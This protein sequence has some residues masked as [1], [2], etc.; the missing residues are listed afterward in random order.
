[1]R[2][3][4]LLARVDDAF[5]VRCCVDVVRFFELVRWSELFR[6]FEPERPDVRAL[7]LRTACSV[8]RRLRVSLSSRLRVLLLRAGEAFFDDD[9]D[10]GRDGESG[11]LDAPRLELCSV[12]LE[13]RSAPLARFALR[14]FFSLV[15]ISRYH[16]RLRK[17]H[18]TL[19]RGRLVRCSLLLSTG[20][21]TMPAHCHGVTRA[22]ARGRSLS[23]R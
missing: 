22:R 17:T 16:S 2:V 5:F 13:L 15:I 11:R 3:E 12:L 4:A 7:A 1:M 14:A 8:L 10:G 9:F 21:Q 20:I 6:C 23:V 18:T 19:G